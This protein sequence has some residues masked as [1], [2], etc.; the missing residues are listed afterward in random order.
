VWSKA[1]TPNPFLPK[2]DQ[3]EQERN[4]EPF[5]RT[6]PPQTKAAQLNRGTPSSAFVTTPPKG[7]RVCA[8]PTGITPNSQTAPD[9]KPPKQPRTKHDPVL[10]C[11][12]TVNGPTT[13][14]PDSK[15]RPPRHIPSTGLTTHLGQHHP[16]P[17]DTIVTGYQPHKAVFTHDCIPPPRH[18]DI[19]AVPSNAACRRFFIIRRRQRPPTSSENATAA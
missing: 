10:R 19:G 14:Q 4:G 11:R 1:K 6:Q 13:D 7:N 17:T 9:T 15:G 8:S 18:K 12:R 16:S 2:P 3:G 5:S